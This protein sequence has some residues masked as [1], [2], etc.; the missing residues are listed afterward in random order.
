[1][2]A[3]PSH[4]RAA[5]SPATDTE[6]ITVPDLDRIRR[7]LAGTTYEDRDLDEEELDADARRRAR[8][9]MLEQ[10]RRAHPPPPLDRLTPEE[11]VRFEEERP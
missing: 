11:R 6:E 3:V 4:D 7:L 9:A 2:R 1:M 10:Y 5:P 8:R